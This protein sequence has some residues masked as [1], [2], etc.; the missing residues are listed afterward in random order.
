M[1][2]DRSKGPFNH[3]CEDVIALLGDFL[4]GDLSEGASRALMR[5]LE[6]SP[7]A[8]F[9]ETLLRTRNAV[10]GLRCDSIP[11]DCHERILEIIKNP[12]AGPMPPQEE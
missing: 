11:A 6:C 2:T 10:R 3:R 4:E 8:E 1:E 12:S 9:L 7:C 5:E